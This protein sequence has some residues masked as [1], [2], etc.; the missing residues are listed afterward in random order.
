MTQINLVRENE[1]EPYSNSGAFASRARF[2]TAWWNTKTTV[3]GCPNITAVC[4]HDRGGIWMF[5]VA[6]RRRS[7]VILKG[8]HC[9]LPSIPSF[10]S[11]GPGD[12]Q[13]CQGSSA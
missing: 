1:M 13:V 6:Q 8:P 12:T 9:L 7:I 4:T 2:I 5:P 11:A 10:E 3:K